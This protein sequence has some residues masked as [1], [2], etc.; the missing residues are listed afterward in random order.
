MKH[1]KTLLCAVLVLTMVLALSACSGNN[2]IVGSWKLTGGNAMALLGVDLGTTSLEELGISVVFTF[3]S[4]GKFISKST[5]IDDEQSVEG[6]W[7]IKEG[8]LVTTVDG[9]ADTSDYKI[10]GNK[11]TITSAVDAQS[12]SIE[13][14]KQ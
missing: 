10:D 2:K 14:T 12:Y 11:L 3:K 9:S 6:T 8:K 13:F 7:E 4:G 5:T 1:I